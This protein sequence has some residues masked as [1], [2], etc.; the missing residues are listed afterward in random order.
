MSSILIAQLCSITA[1]EM[2]GLRHLAETITESNHGG[3]S[4]EARLIEYSP[5]SWAMEIRFAQ[6][7]SELQRRTVKSTM[8]LAMS[9]CREVGPGTYFVRGYQDEPPTPFFATA[10]ASVDIRDYL[11]YGFPLKLILTTEECLVELDLDWL[12]TVIRENFSGQISPK[13]NCEFLIWEVNAKNLF[14][15]VSAL[16]CAIG[17]TAYRLQSEGK[18]ERKILRSVHREDCG[19]VN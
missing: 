2:E 1:I 6:H 12:M 4:Q 13:E 19:V 3:F 15:F 8:D 7:L 18:P 16:L 9:I 14:Y 10:R 11:C 5:F 17:P